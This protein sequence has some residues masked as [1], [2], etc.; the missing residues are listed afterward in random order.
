MAVEREIAGIRCGEVLAELS[1]YLDGELAPARRTQVDAHLLGCDACE[2]FGSRFSAALRAIRQSGS[3]PSGDE[4]GVYERLGARL[5]QAV[6][7][8]PGT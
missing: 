6:K 2:R 3:G 7:E 5:H 4:P 8:G 1:D